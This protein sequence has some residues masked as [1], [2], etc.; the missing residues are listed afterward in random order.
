MQ[1]RQRQGDVMSMM[2]QRFTGSVT[3]RG[4]IDGSAFD[5]WVERSLAGR[6]TGSLAEDLPEEWLT[7]A[8]RLPVRISGGTD[9]H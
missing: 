4:P 3:P 7:L 1:P 9:G 2:T 8:S 5:L 6:F